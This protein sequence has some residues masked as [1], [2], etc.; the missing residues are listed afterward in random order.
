MQ[1]LRQLGVVLLGRKQSHRKRSPVRSTDRDRVIAVSEYKQRLAAKH[2]TDAGRN[3]TAARSPVNAVRTRRH[4]KT[5]PRCISAVDHGA[6]TP[7]VALDSADVG[8]GGYLPGL[9]YTVL[10]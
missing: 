8:G 5:R 3:E 2:D 6:V 9:L 1:S 4:R 10:R 7:P